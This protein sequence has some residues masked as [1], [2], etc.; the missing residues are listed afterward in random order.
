LTSARRAAA[1]A[2]AACALP[3]A[4]HGYVRSRTTNGS[5]PTYWPSSCAFVQPDSGGSADLPLETVVDVAKKSMDNWNSQT[6]ACSYFTLFLVDPA[7]GDAHFDGKNVIHF[8]TDMWCHPLDGAP[9]EKRHCYDPSAAGITTIFYADHPGKTDDGQILDADVELNAINFTFVIVTPG[10]TPAVRGDTSV[11]DL[12]N[13]LTHELGHLQGLDHT[14]KDMATPPNALDE[15]GNTPPLCTQV[16]QLDPATQIKIRDATMYNQAQPM[17]TKK[18]MPKPDDIAGICAAYP[19]STSPVPKCAPADL[20]SYQPHGCAVG[21]R[22][23]P[24]WLALFPL[25]LCALAGLGRARARPPR[26][27]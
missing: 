17:E 25:A 26:P 8:R 19:A 13:T 7:P 2:L 11:A 6:S 10:V 22:G 27:A 24:S 1:L 20:R 14:C 21:G 16:V 3:S 18:R 9:P 5:T 12:E 4:A 23:K 15:N